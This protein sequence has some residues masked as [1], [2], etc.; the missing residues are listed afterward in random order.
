MEVSFQLVTAEAEIREFLSHVM[1]EGS[2]VCSRVFEFEA[3]LVEAPEGA[4]L[5]E[6]RSDVWIELPHCLSFIDGSLKD[7]SSAVVISD[8]RG[9]V[10]VET[11]ALFSEGYPY[12]NLPVRHFSRFCVVYSPKKRFEPALHVRKALPKLNAYNSLEKYRADGSAHA[13]SKQLKQAAQTAASSP[14][15]AEKRMLFFEMKKTSSEASAEE[16]QK[17]ALIRQDARTN[18]SDEDAME[19]DQPAPISSAS[20]A[21][22]VCMHECVCACGVYVCGVW[23]EEVMKLVE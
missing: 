5:D 21:V 18:L 8:R 20:N 12:V 14:S 16:Q 6:F 10:A 22:R 7:Y 1:F 19:V 23:G 13:Y 17:Q 15:A 11:Q 4:K 3:K 9:K 2:V